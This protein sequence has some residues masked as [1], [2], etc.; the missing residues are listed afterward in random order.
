M[1]R[2][3][4]GNANG[5]MGSGANRGL[6]RSLS[7]HESAIR[8][9]D[10]ETLIVLDENG[11]VLVNKKGGSHSVAYGADGIKTA[12][13]I[14]THNHPNGS[15]FSWND[16]GGMVYYNQK[17]MRATGKEFTFSMKR[18]E[19]GWG[20]SHEKAAARFKKALSSARA[21]YKKQKTGNAAIDRKL[22]I[23]LTHK[24]NENAAKSFGWD[25]SMK[26]NK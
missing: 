7:V 23:D 26:K 1:G 9:N 2:G 8:G 5:G 25:Y 18:P 17:E 19:K 22:W 13:A 24:Y 12:N 20:V 6:T 4:G 21:A 16:I 11:N 14:V 15:S 3:A 10:Y